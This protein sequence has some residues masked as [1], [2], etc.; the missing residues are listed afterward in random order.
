VSPEAARHDEPVASAK[1][2]VKL[3]PKV[4]GELGLISTVLGCRENRDRIEFA[5]D[6]KKFVEQSNGDENDKKKGKAASNGLA[7]DYLLKLT[8][9]L[10]QFVRQSKV[11]DLAQAMPKYDFISPSLALLLMG[12][13]RRMLVE[14]EIFEILNEKENETKLPFDALRDLCAR[15]DKIFTDEHCAFITASYL[16]EINEAVIYIN[17][18]EFLSDLKDPRSR[19][20]DVAS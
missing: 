20:L 18:K 3:D 19:D 4:D 14:S 17:F 13:V 15:F 5:I 1:E 2:E 16:T 9:G 11:A 8:P 10:E 7:S 12:E 6:L